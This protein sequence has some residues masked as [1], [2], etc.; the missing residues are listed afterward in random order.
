VRLADQF[1]AGFS[2]PTFASNPK[3]LELKGLKIFHTRVPAEM[4]AK[5]HSGRIL[6]NL[7]KL[8]HYSITGAKPAVV[9]SSLQ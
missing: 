7:G 4:P 2:S 1:S 8:A 3:Q 5:Q 6:D 9:S